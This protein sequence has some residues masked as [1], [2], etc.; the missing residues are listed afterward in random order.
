MDVEKPGYQVTTIKRNNVAVETGD[1]LA[2]VISQDGGMIAFKESRI[3]SFI[4]DKSGKQLSA[5][6]HV[7]K[8]N[9]SLLIRPY[10]AKP[11]VYNVTVHPKKTGNVVFSFYASVKSNPGVQLMAQRTVQVQVSKRLLQNYL[12]F[13]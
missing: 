9:V 1:I 4:F 10:Y 2:I 11:L 3:P 7:K 8:L 13:K 5:H 12:E 6:K